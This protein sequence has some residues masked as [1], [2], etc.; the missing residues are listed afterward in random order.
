MITVDY[1]ERI[2]I[3]I[4]QRKKHIGQN[5]RKYKIQSFQ[6]SSHHAVET[7]LFSQHPCVTVCVDYCQPGKLTH[8][9]LGIQFLLGLCH[10]A[11]VD[12]LCC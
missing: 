6:L 8:L 5:V 10:V 9:S 3:K 4:N 2:Q 7:A 11:M 1:R 12:C